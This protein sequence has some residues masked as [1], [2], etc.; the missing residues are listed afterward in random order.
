MKSVKMS[1]R[2]GDVVEVISG[3]DKGRQGKVIAVDTR[4]N[5]VLIEGI[6]MIKRHERPRG[7]TKPGGIIEKPAYLDR[8]NVMLVCPKCSKPSRVGWEKRGEKRVRVCKNCG[9]EVSA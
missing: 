3:D 2:K 5:R 9:G 4:K 1:V 8:S 7:S 6:N